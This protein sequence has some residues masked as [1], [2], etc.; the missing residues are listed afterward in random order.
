MPCYLPQFWPITCLQI[1]LVRG[2]HNQVTRRAAHKSRDVD[3]KNEL[4]I[5]EG[6]LTPMYNISFSLKGRIRV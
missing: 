3:S 1:G 5:S 4:L 6:L 2:K